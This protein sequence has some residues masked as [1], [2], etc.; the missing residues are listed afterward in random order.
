[1]QED[2]LIVKKALDTIAIAEK[3]YAVKSLGFLDPREEALINREIRGMVPADIV[4]E[5]FGGTDEAERKMFI[6]RPEYLE[7]DYDEIITALE[8]TGRDISSLSHRDYLGSLMG[9]GIKRENIGDIVPV[10]DENKCYIFLKPA[11][12]NYVGENLTK[13]GRCGVRV[14]PRNLSE[15]QVPEKPVKPIAATVSS[16]RLDC[17]VS[18][19]TGLARGKAA[20]II[21]SERVKLNFEVTDG[22]SAALSEGDIISIRGFGRYRLSEIRGTTRKGRISVIID[23][24]I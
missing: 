22:V 18:A 15:I 10:S 4:C 14:S 16:L 9:L 5:F 17:L 12:L 7:T 20:D 1:M 13:I 24:Y 8:I 6:C 19:A 11:M 3:Q 21:K 23:K 2:K